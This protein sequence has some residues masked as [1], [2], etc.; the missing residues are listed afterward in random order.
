MPGV[1]SRGIDVLEVRFRKTFVYDRP[2]SIIPSRTCQYFV[3][4]N[5]DLMLLLRQ[6]YLD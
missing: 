2:V 4:Q 6:H 3:F 5:S 1:F